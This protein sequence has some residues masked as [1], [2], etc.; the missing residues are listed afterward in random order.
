MSTYTLTYADNVKGW[1]S[2]Y[3]FY[4]DWMIG[5]NN[6]F[7][8]FKGGDLYR[9]NDNGLRNT[10]YYDWWFKK[11]QANQATK[12]STII[13]VLNPSPVQNLL[14]KTIDIQ[15]DSPWD[16]QL[17]TDLQN[18]GFITSSWFDKKEST[19]FA[20]VRNDNSGELSLR[21]L[22]GIGK[23]VSV[24]GANDEVNFSTNPLIVIDSM[25][26]IGDYLY[27]VDTT[28]QLPKLA[29]EITAINRNYITG[30]NQIVIN[31]AIPGTVAIPGV[32][33]NIEFFYVKNSVAESH[34]VL[35]HYCKFSMQNGSTSKIELFAVE[36][37]IMK[38]YP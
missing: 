15:G 16:I 6:Y 4:P 32:L 34:G 25:A 36:S 20:F 1:V 8:T 3:S 19:Y 7:Y 14:F 22:N 13:S 35:G 5:T 12:P 9:H 17:E 30:V 26:S 33:T 2:F 21:S 29:G 38:S 28:N 27:F 31:T 37:D 11:N 18:S 10:F 23:C 24:T